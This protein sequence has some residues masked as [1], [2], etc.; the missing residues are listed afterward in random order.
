MFKKTMLLMLLLILTFSITSM[1]QKRRCVGLK[2]DDC[3]VVIERVEAGYSRPFF[4]NGDWRSPFVDV[5]W[6]NRKTTP[7]TIRAAK[8]KVIMFNVMRE[9]YRTEEVMT[10]YE[11]LVPGKSNKDA[12]RW[13]SWVEEPEAFHFYVAVEKLL[14][15]DGTIWIRQNE[16]LFDKIEEE[17]APE[18]P[19]HSLI[20]AQERERESK[21]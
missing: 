13:P 2:D 4:A 8:F 10:S 7:K 14:F 18:V 5:W 12:W 11:N 21:Q 3:P 6:R 20:E 15:D 9:H 17:M 1:A 19:I 16:T